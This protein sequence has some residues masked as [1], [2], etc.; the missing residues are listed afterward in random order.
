MLQSKEW[1]FRQ[2]QYTQLAV[3]WGPSPLAPL[4]CSLLCGYSADKKVTAHE[5]PYPTI[6]NPLLE[7]TA[8]NLRLFGDTLFA[9]VPTAIFRVC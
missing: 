1:T 5:T 9:T 8:R 2:D 4:L 7:N 3:P 6:S